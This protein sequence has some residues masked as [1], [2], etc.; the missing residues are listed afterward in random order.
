[1]FDNEIRGQLA[2]LMGGRAAEE[3]TCG[4]LS[5]GMFLAP[6]WRLFDPIKTPVPDPSLHLACDAY[7]ADVGPLL[8]FF[9]TPAQPLLAH[10]FRLP[11]DDSSNT[12]AIHHSQ[13]T[14][15]RNVF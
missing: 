13:K 4:H 1:M 5:T 7:W 9:L 10:M 12:K 8:N 14:S 15:G 6:C 11:A 2:T 3:L